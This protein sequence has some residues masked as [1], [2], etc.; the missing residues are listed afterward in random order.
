MA[1]EF[2]GRDPESDDGHSPTVWRDPV[3]GD[4]VLQGW[5][6]SD[7]EMAEVGEVPPH[8][9]VIR[10]P[11]RMMGFFPEVSGGGPEPR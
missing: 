8:E 6:L 7:V 11:A 9:T 4:Y 5:R 2:L 1:L 3:S 10:F